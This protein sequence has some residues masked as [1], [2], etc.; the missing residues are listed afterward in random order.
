M[1]IYD[2][3]DKRNKRKKG[4]GNIRLEQVKDN[5]NEFQ[6]FIY[7]QQDSMSIEYVISTTTKEFLF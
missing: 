6:N 1:Y 5:D 4:E 3:N 7:I 2:G